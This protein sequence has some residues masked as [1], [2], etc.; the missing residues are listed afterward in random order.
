ME[1]GNRFLRG[2]GR[3]ASLLCGVLF[4]AAV[5]ASQASAQQDP[6]PDGAGKD[7]FLKTCSK[8]HDPSNVIGKGRSADDWTATLNKMIQYGASGTDEDFQ[9]ILDYLS[10]YFGP[11]PDKINVNKATS[12]DFRNWLNFTQKMADAAV[13]YRTENGPFR[14]VDDLKKVPGIDPKLIDAK[15]DHLTF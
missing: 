12:L 1:R 10:M 13:A 6:F 2:R 3:A 14:S 9:A 5:F 11:P 15:K 4:A 8:C 7:V